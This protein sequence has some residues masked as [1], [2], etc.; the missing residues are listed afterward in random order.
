MFL[1][2]NFN[3]FQYKHINIG[4]HIFILKINLRQI[5]LKIIF[6][7]VQINTTSKCILNVKNVEFQ[8]SQIKM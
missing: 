5:T 3:Y 6:D 7:Y 8:E 2:N 4:L 1:V